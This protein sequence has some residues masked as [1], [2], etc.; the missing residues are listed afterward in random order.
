M[1]LKVRN[2]EKSFQTADGPQP[3]L[4]GISLDLAAGETLALTGESGSG[5]S[6][7]LHLIAGLDTPD[8]GQIEIDGHEIG[9]LSDKRRAALRRERVG[10]IF[11]QFN[12]IPSLNVADNLTFHARLAGRTAN[13][14]ALA[15]SLGLLD[16]LTRYPEQLS[17]GQ[18]Q[19]VAIG[20]AMAMG[21]GLILADEPTG[22]LDEATAD[23]MIAVLSE[24]V[25]VTGAGLLMVTHSER[26]ARAMDRRLHLAAGRL[27]SPAESATPVRIVQ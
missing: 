3:V 11:Q 25:R 5:K 27:K 9:T 17:G 24:A 13:A 23:A 4:R 22:N 10:L 18:Q 20:R 26:L 7:L 16:H 14:A 15:E 21:P 19:R 12:L 1:L 2:V 8:A 6:T